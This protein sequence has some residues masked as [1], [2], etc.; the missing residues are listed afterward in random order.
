MELINKPEKMGSSDGTNVAFKDHNGRL[1]GFH[2]KKRENYRVPFMLVERRKKIHE[3]RQ[4][5]ARILFQ[6]LSFMNL[7][8]SNPYKYISNFKP[9]N[10]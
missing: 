3:E 6:C 7:H 8:T 2:S 10:A 4:I 1:I 9:C 5:I